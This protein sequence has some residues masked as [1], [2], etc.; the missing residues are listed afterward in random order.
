M[1]GKQV[2]GMKLKDKLSYMEL[3]IEDIIN[4]LRSIRWW[5]GLVVMRWS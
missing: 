5:F 3:R 2:C 4:A 1:G